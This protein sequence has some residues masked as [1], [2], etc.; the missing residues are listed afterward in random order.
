MMDIRHIIGTQPSIADP[1]G[2]HWLA[3]DR[4]R[5]QAF[6][7]AKRGHSDDR[8]ALMLYTI[9]PREEVGGTITGGCLKT[10]TDAPFGAAKQ[11]NGIQWGMAVAGMN[12]PVDAI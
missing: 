2:D 5:G 4:G 3:R 10:D 6:C 9:D 8:P 1:F 11:P 12:L 7:S